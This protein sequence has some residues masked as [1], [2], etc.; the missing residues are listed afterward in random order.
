MVSGKRDPV[1]NSLLLPA[2]SARSRLIFKTTQWV[3]VRPRTRTVWTE[4]RVLPR[5][6]VFPERIA[7]RHRL[8]T[9]GSLTGSLHGFSKFLD[10]FL[11]IETGRLSHRSALSNLIRIDKDWQL[12]IKQKW[13]KWTWGFRFCFTVRLLSVS[14]DV[15][16]LLCRRV[17]VCVYYLKNAGQSLRAVRVYL[18]PSSLTC[19]HQLRD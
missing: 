11:R 14:L 18:S 3:R 12:F 1:I 15:W 8:D 9:S 4:F 19:N 5:Q 6:Q 17:S 10:I 16:R 13:H 2:G 7:Q